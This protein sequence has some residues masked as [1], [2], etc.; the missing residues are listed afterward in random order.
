MA[1]RCDS[2]ATAGCG[3]WRTAAIRVQLTTLKATAVPCL[4]LETEGE[5]VRAAELSMIMAD[6][7]SKPFRHHTY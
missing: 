6:G 4:E 5:T 3:G 7:S 1:K 2:P